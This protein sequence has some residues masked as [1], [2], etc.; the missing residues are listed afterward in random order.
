MQLSPRGSA[1]I[2]VSEKT[3]ASSPWGRSCLI[4]GEKKEGKDKIFQTVRRVLSRPFFI[5]FEIFIKRRGAMFFAVRSRLTAGVCR[6][7]K[8]GFGLFPSKRTF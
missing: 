4:G 5:Y 2:L 1:E 3:W 8:R 6:L 7:K